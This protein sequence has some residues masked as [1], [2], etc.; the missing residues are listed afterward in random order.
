MKVLLVCFCPPIGAI[1]DNIKE[2]VYYLQSR[3]TLSVVAPISL[4]LERS[5]KA[6]LISIDYEKVEPKFLFYS[7]TRDAL[8]LCRALDV[9][10]VFF[11]STCIFNAVFA[12]VLRDLPHVMWWHEPTKNRRLSIFRTS[13]NFICD[14]WMQ[15]SSNHI[16]FAS[17][18]FVKFL[19]PKFRNSNNHSVIRLPL[20]QDFVSKNECSIGIGSSNQ[21]QVD[22]LF[23]GSVEEYKGLEL[24]CSA[25]KIL[26][27]RSILPTVRILGFG[28]VYSIAP[29]LAA[30]AKEHPDQVV[31]EQGFHSVEKISSA[32]SN[33]RFSV[34]PYLSVSASNTIPI[35][36]ANKRPVIATN[37]GYFQEII[38]DGENGFL[39]KT[40][41]AN[42]LA[43]TIENA[44][45]LSTDRWKIM[46][47]SAGLT[48]TE[49]SAAKI[50][51]ELTRSFAKSIRAHSEEKGFARGRH[52]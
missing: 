1:A 41:D 35:V 2:L 11:F 31:I 36:W 10:V 23:F 30:Y 44:I 4:H 14:R 34:F 12:N 22:L 24:L 17:A 26:R 45:R 42:S 6:Q 37:L 21:S 20:L 18:E 3:V 8:K 50:S 28:D 52:R 40:R 46:S 19:P 33:A 5:A 47:E 27:N 9:D 48:S 25:I 38:S 15:R 51:D 43:R 39:F 13:W 16:V 29:K 32:I 49:F 7:S